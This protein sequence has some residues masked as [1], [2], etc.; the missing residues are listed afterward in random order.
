MQLVLSYFSLKEIKKNLNSTENTKIHL[1]ILEKF[2][3]RFKK[4]SDK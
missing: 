4:S 1:G 2:V 3:Q